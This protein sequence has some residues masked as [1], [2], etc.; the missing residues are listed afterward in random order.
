MSKINNPQNEIQ[1]IATAY[2]YTINQLCEKLG[3]EG[4]KLEYGFT[5]EAVRRD[6]QEAMRVL[7][8]FR[9]AGYTA[10]RQ[11]QES[12]RPQ[13]RGYTP[14]ASETGRYNPAGMLGYG[15]DEDDEVF[16]G[17]RS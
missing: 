11:E 2:G 4:V 17:R 15:E 13:T 9:E 1:A 12:Q 7:A 14:K 8:A 6:K 3:I 5:K 10:P 16:C